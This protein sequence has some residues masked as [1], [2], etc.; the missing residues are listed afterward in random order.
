RLKFLGDAVLNIIIVTAIFEENPN[1]SHKN[2]SQI[3]AALIN[4][5]LLVFLYLEVSLI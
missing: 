4:A 2:I 3:K 5:D 1:C